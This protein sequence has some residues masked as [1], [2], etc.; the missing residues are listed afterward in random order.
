M[1][2]QRRNRRERWRPWHPR[3]KSDGRSPF[4]G[5]RS[6]RSVPGRGLEPLRPC[7]HQIL[8]LARLPISPPRPDDDAYGTPDRPAPGP[9]P[10]PVV[11][12][13]SHRVAPDRRHRGPAERRPFPVLSIMGVRGR[14]PSIAAGPRSGPSPVFSFIWST[15]G[16]PE[17]CP[18][19]QPERAWHRKLT[20]LLSVRGS[21]PLPSFLGN[22][23]VGQ[24]IRQFLRS[25]PSHPADG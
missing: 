8:S 19:G 13:S 18:A 14:C 4:V 17:Q 7:G 25:R 24:S 20:R 3:Q 23:H 9:I 2:S 10:R 22:F 6:S 11:Y 5:R 1:R 15:P 21:S 16:C 12:A